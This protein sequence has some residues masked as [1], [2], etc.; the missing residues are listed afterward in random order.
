MI[1]ALPE[2]YS[3][4][5]YNLWEVEK[6]EE[7]ASLHVVVK[8]DADSENVTKKIKKIVGVEDCTVQ[9]IRLR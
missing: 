7:V 4:K 5:T 3:V 6:G 9:L 2:V 1:E 8:K